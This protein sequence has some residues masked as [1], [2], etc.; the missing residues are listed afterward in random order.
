[1]VS[2]ECRINRLF[3]EF[4]EAQPCRSRGDCIF[5]QLVETQ[6]CR[7]GAS[8]LIGL[9]G[10]FEHLREIQQ[11]VCPMVDKVVSPRRSPHSL[12]SE[13]FGLSKLCTLCEHP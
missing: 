2:H 3:F 10:C 8:R 7:G 4:A 11:R 12:A 6:R 9:A 1:M 5:L 13:R